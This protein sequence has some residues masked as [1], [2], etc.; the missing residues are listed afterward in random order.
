MKRFNVILLIA[1]I[2]ILF[3]VSS[4]FTQVFVPG[5][6]RSNGTYIQPHYRSS[7]DGT[8][9]N[10]W[11]FKNNINPYT[12]QEGHNYNKHSPS[13]PFYDGSSSSYK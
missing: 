10:N 2:A 1:L 6:Y 8:V 4:A 9:T 5:H 12:G 11:S 3:I 7:P 13:S